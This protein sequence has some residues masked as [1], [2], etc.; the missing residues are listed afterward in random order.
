MSD[1]R[2]GNQR[3]QS[4]ARPAHAGKNDR[5]NIAHV[6]KQL[7]KS[8][9]LADILNGGEEFLRHLAPE[10]RDELVRIARAVRY[11]LVHHAHGDGAM[12]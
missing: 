3:S 1:T 8:G 11:A 9:R 2:I 5:Y 7:A 6:A 12:A 4:R 10:V